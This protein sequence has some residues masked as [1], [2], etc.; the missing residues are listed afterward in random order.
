MHSQIIENDLVAQ[1][2]EHP[3]FNREGHGVRRFFKIVYDLVAQLVEQYTFNVWALG[4]SPSGI[5]ETTKAS[6]LNLKPF[7]FYLP[8]GK[9]YF[10]LKGGYFAFRVL[11]FLYL[12]ISDNQR[13]PHDHVT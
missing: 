12:K 8:A 13:Q 5:T 9:Q 1:L 11:S 4:S 7:F 2:V 6:N 10:K 3:D